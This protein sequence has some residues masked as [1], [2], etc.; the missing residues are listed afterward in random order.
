MLPLLT[1]GG[2][3]INC[4]PHPFIPAGRAGLPSPPT[5]LLPVCAVALVWGIWWLLRDWQ[6][7]LLPRSRVSPP[8]LWRRC[9]SLRSFAAIRED[10]LV[11][12]IFYLHQVSWFCNPSLRLK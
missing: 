7:R 2:F 6:P 4:Y 12:E 5:R 11:P 9:F 1:M 10:A 3:K 8:V